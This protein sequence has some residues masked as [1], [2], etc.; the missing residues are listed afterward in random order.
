MKKF[1]IL[2][3]LLIIACI[4]ATSCGKKSENL[5]GSLKDIIDDI[6]KGV[7]HVMPQLEQVS[8]TDDNIESY[9]GTSD[10]DY[11]EGL[12]SEPMMSAIAHSVVLIRM[13][14]GS[15]IEAAKELIR[16]SVNPKKW[17]Y[18]EVDPS[19]VIV[20]SRGDIIILIMVDDYSNEFQESFHNLK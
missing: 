11:K 18:V 20:D 1:R 7:N 8:I 4:F 2:G 10:I 6:Y 3:S 17:I 5:E 13:N 16:K 15:D 9:L 14:E 12:A 19:D